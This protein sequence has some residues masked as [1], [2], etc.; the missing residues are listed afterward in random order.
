M[1][2]AI[3]HCSLGWL[4]THSLSVMLRNTYDRTDL[5]IENATTRERAVAGVIAISNKNQVV[6]PSPSFFQ[7]QLLSSIYLTFTCLVCHV[8]IGLC[9][10][11]FGFS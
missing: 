1:T 6:C 4:A 8:S 3:F 11:S 10:G 2:L 5:H 9:S 7:E